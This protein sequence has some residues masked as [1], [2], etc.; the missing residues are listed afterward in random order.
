MV[1]SNDDGRLDFRFSLDPD[2]AHSR[3]FDFA[4]R[5]EGVERGRVEFERSVI[6]FR[7]FDEPPAGLITCAREGAQH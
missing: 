3:L 5:L 6:G 1:R 4:G 7:R 2:A